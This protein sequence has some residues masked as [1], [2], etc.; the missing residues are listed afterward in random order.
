MNC[1][2]GLPQAAGE[3]VYLQERLLCPEIADEQVSWGQVLATV[4]GRFSEIIEAHGPDAVAF[5]V[6]G[7]LLTEDYKAVWIMAT[8]PVVTLPEADRVASALEKY[9]LVVLSDCVR[10]TEIYIYSPS[11]THLWGC[12]LTTVQQN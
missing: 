1:A 5:Y 4:A 2:S 9:E 3:T 6:S 11:C 7:Q 8:N 10:E 12:P